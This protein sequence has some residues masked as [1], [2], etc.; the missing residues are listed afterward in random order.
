MHSKPHSFVK[1]GI[2][3]I[4]LPSPF[5]LM[6]TRLFKLDYFF[7]D[8]LVNICICGCRNAANVNFYKRIYLLSLF[9][10]AEIVGTQIEYK[11]GS[12]LISF[13]ESHLKLLASLGEQYI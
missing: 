4:Y 6:V 1:M 3:C 9:L 7:P 13:K 11:Q 12:S 5:C 2:L 10:N 8:F